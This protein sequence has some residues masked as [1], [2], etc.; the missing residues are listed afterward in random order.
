[1]VLGGVLNPGDRVIVGAKEGRLTF[2]V[3]EG[4]AAS[5]SYFRTVWLFC[6]T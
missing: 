5:W 2:E 3:L 1:M 6:S 4:A